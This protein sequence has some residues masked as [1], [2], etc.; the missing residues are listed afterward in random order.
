VQG[1]ARLPVDDAPIM[2]RGGEG[3]VYEAVDELGSSARRLRGAASLRY[4]V[5]ILFADG[6]EPELA[7][8]FAVGDAPPS[9]QPPGR[10]AR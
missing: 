6:S 9:G 7:G 1:A 2:A 10:R 5:E 3:S 4:L 8:P